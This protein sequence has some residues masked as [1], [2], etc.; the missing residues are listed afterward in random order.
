MTTVHTVTAIAM[1]LLREESLNLEQIM[2]V[3]QAVQ[4]HAAASGDHPRRPPVLD[5][6]LL[7]AG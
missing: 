1:S 4:D 6:V 2:A 3:V 5:P 7:P